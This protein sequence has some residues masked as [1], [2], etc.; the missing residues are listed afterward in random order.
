MTMSDFFRV[1]KKN[2]FKVGSFSTEIS[3]RDEMQYGSEVRSTDKYYFILEQ[4]PS[5]KYSTLV[6]WP[7]VQLQPS[8]RFHYL[9]VCLTFPMRLKEVK[10]TELSLAFILEAWAHKATLT[11]RPFPIYFISP[12]HFSNNF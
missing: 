3:S 8:A 9:L 1:V 6:G 5:L 10:I 4:K 12:S 2:Y 11:Q 7:T